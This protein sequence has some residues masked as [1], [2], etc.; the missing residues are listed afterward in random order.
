VNPSAPNPVTLS[1]RDIAPCESVDGV[2]LTST[3]IAAPLLLQSR[4]PSL[5]AATVPSWAF[6]CI[7]QSA[8]YCKGYDGGGID[9]TYNYRMQAADRRYPTGLLPSR[10]RTDRILHEAAVTADP[11]LLIRLFGISVKTAM[12]YLRSA[13]PDRG[14]VL[15]R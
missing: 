3:K 12:R 1:P 10:L 8:L 5:N 2:T 11:V 4:Y 13:H 14:S 15:P 6:G 7:L 9:G